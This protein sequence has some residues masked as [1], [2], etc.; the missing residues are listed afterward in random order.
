MAM[1]RCLLAFIVIALACSPAFSQR[2][3]VAE[4]KARFQMLLRW[5]RTGDV[6]SRHTA[7]EEMVKFDQWI[8]AELLKRVGKA[9]DAERQ[10]FWTVLYDRRCRKALEPAYQRLP[11]AIKQCRDA[12]IAVHKILQLRQ[13]ANRAERK[14]DAGAAQKLTDEAN[15]LRRSVPWN[16]ITLGNEVSILVGFCVEFGHEREFMKLMQLAIDSSMDDPLAKG[17]K[18]RRW[19]TYRDKPLPGGTDMWNTVYTPVWE[20][21]Q[22]LS[23]RPLDQKRV[24]TARD[25]FFRHFEQLAKKKDLGPNQVAALQNFER[26]RAAMLKTDTHREETEEE[27]EDGTGIIRK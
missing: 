17:L 13:R 19:R 9:R 25:R 12:Q 26:A 3:T 16:E 14:G 11:G 27:N 10:L 18:S 21:V 20:A 4:E 2:K 6:P 8:D 15:A 22:K 24:G 5:A 1:K 7:H 23:R